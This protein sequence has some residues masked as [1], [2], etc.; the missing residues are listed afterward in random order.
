MIAKLRSS[1][2]AP[3]LLL[4][5]EF[6]A[7]YTQRTPGVSQDIDRHTVGEATANALWSAVE[8]VLTRHPKGIR[9]LGVHIPDHYWTVARLPVTDSSEPQQAMH[10]HLAS[11]LP[12]DINHY[13]YAIHVSRPAG[14]PVAH[15][16]ISEKHVIESL[17]DR[18]KKAKLQLKRVQPRIVSII[19][20]A[21][22]THQLNTGL[23]L[24]VDRSASAISLAVMRN[25]QLERCRIVPQPERD[26]GEDVELAHVHAT[27]EAYGAA[28]QQPL[29]TYVTP[30]AAAI[31]QE[32]ERVQTLS[33]QTIE[34]SEYRGIKTAMQG[35]AWTERL[36]DDTRDS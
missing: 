1:T 16:F 2:A 25:G 15:A 28:R 14:T 6:D 18:A 31:F 22:K 8:T 26:I 3:T 12:D 33:V 21:T 19:N 27:A 32:P 29:S 36:E 23:T 35:L 34:D 10:N 5:V 30:R 7:I 17:D 20:A 4:D 11:C 24:I 9:R 13:T